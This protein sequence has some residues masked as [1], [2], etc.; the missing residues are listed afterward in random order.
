MARWGKGKARV[1]SLIDAGELDEVPPSE[2]T[3]R[4]LLSSG[5]RHIASAASTMATDPEGAL[6]LAYD[7]ARKGATGVLAHQG[8]RPTTRGGHRVVVDAVEAQ[9]PG[10]PG[11][12]SLDRLR[13]RRNQSE[14]PDTGYDPVTSQEAAD[15]VQVA[16][17]SI[18]SARRLIDEAG[19]GLFR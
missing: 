6:A 14:Y 10:V 3:T 19:L 13:R 1:Q 18:S 2:D 11:L 7:A 8:L 16:T 17:D 12:Q 15:A 9:F 5:E 4:A